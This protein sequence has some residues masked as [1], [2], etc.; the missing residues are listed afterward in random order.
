MEDTLPARVRFGA[1][2]LDLNAGELRLAAAAG[3][4]PGDR[5]VLPQQP[6]QVLC[7]L[8]ERDGAIVTREEIRKRFW[9]NDTIVEFD[10]SINV[11]IGKLRKALGDS[12]DDPKYIG[13]VASRGYRLMV[14]VQRMGSSSDDTAP[15]EENAGSEEAR[16]ALPKHRPTNLGGKT[17]SHYR[18]LEIIGGGGMGVV[19]RGEDIKLDR[20][21]A[22]KVLPEELGNDSAAVERFEREAR[23]T[24]VLDHPNICS[25]YEFGEHQ[26]QPFI[27]MQLLRG[28]TLRD[29]LV[30]A[31]GSHPT[32]PIEAVFTLDELLNVAIQ[33]V[34]GLEAA[35]EKGIIHRDIKP[36]NI[37]VTDK[38]V[39]KILDFGLAKLLEL[40]Q[41]EGQTTEQ[42][43]HGTN[44]PRNT[45]AARA[46]QL[47]RIGQA[48]GTAAYM[49]PEQVKGE[50]LD[51]RTDLFSFGLVL[52]EMATGQRAFS[53]ETEAVLHA[54][55]VRATPPPV[56]SLNSLLPPEL[57][58][59]I[60]KA[61]EKDRERRYRSAAALRADLA[62]LRHGPESGSLGPAP[63]SGPRV[64][65][66][67]LLWAAMAAVLAGLLA[68][69]SYF[70]SHKSAALTVKDT[71]VLADFA[72]STNDPVFDG[73]LRQ[74]L[75]IQLEQSPFLNV[76]SDQ[77]ISETLKFMNRPANE[78]LTQ[79]LTQEVCLRNNSKA[80]L[81]GSIAPVG[82]HYLITLTALN[83]QTGEP[84]ASAEAEAENRNQ[85]LKKVREIANQLRGTLG[86]SL[87]SVKKFDQPLEEATTPS[88][89][90]LQAFTRARRIMMAGGGADAIPY[91]QHALELDPV[92]P[93]AR[94]ALGETYFNLGQNS[95]AIENLKKAY[96]SRSQVS[97]R[98]RLAIEAIYYIVVTGDLERAI[99]TYQDWSSTY[100]T[101][102]IPHNNLGDLYG[103]LGQY[104]KAEGETQESI[105]VA[106]GNVDYSNLVIILIAR[107]KLDEGEAAFAAAR[108][109][110]L[111]GLFLRMCQY[112]IAFLRAQDSVMQEQLTWAL[113]KPEVEDVLLALQADTEAYYGRFERARSFS[114]H[115]VESAGLVD[116][117]E[118][119]AGWRAKEALREAE[120]GDFS[121]A[122]QMAAEA[123]NLSPGRDV[124]VMRALT[125]ARVGD[126]PQAQKLADKINQDYPL[127][128]LMQGYWLPTIR[129]AIA[130]DRG[131]AQ[132]AIAELEGAAYELGTTMPARFLGGPMYP[133]YLRGLAYLKSGQ[134]KPAAAEL[135]KMLDH[136]CLV[137]NYVS[138]ALARLQLGRAQAMMG[139]KVAA[140]K[141]Y[142]DFL[143][144]WKDADPDIPIYQQ[145]KAEYT[146]LQ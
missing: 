104:T 64:R 74:A 96:E 5:I 43:Q 2:E 58:P 46:K 17:I 11:A 82:E 38:G 99:Q 54:A 55:I 57:E 105:R 25:I 95:L 75:A 140:R 51:A 60:S 19:Y 133:V 65:R 9:P 106:P 80:L 125:L 48:L 23:A 66:R 101:D 135:Q 92:F 120:I 79:E 4:E 10:H 67:W 28:Q 20:A 118:S 136:R 116:A 34:D 45:P 70:L 27:V 138:G 127:D 61:L 110:N 76:L 30:A 145:A 139:D 97:Q 123:S 29:R 53:G 13:T 130:L 81:A 134:G 59:I 68:G 41:E 87:A 86:E 91:L 124:Q 26:G 63:V 33:I 12:A 52:Y 85:V 94:S 18:I 88:L 39:V 77:K 31:Q 15:S 131:N 121:R 73:T 119:A 137:G 72:N 62:M 83:C 22:V 40:G 8:I 115:A 108:S 144:P 6:L 98:E 42:I 112:Y 84:L 35:H 7:M 14:R 1:F 126:A 132:Q 107:G 21:V 49:S 122:R 141:S 44:L 3:D 37:F 142:Q 78:R 113:G 111:D 128:T 100:P 24:S 47:T 71:I 114:Q 146:S 103:R 16:A 117:R 109:R 93:P 32:Q 129:A 36:A 56:R 69:G 143:A 102:Y 90:A 50:Q 89:E